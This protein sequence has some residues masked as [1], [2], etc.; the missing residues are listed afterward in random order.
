MDAPSFADMT[1][2]GF[3]D[4]TAAKVP[5]PG[6]G[7]VAGVAG[8][9][10]AALAGMV[11]SYSLG[12]KAFA[13]QQAQLELDASLLTRARAM[14][15]RLAE[16]D[17]AAYGLVNELSRLPE[18]DPRRVAEMAT[19]AQAAVDVPMAVATLSLDL[20]REYARLVTMTNRHLRSDLA[21]A[22]VLAAATARSAWW[23]VV[24][25][26]PGLPEGD[27]AGVLATVEAMVA[28][29]EDVARDVERGCREPMP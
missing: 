23:N 4:A 8:A 3:L 2:A 10:S 13:A 14:F 1:V 7:A 5:T 17:A 18:A 20:L 22:A 24:V 25:N 28:K 11:V 29:A 19:A 6:G 16:E 12:K 26:V 21:M 27:R 15:M 9:M